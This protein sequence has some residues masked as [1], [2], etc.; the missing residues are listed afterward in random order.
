MQYSPDLSLLLDYLRLLSL[1]LIPVGLLL[2]LYGYKLFKLFIGLIGFLGGSVVGFSLSFVAGDA[3]ITSLLCG[4]IGAFLFYALYRI[5]LF[6]TG[7][8]FGGVISLI[9]VTGISGDV[10]IASFLAGGILGGMLALQLEKLIVIILSSCKGAV[11]VLGGSALL[12]FPEQQ[13]QLIDTVS[14]NPQALIS[15]ILNYFLLLFIVAL[16]GI[17]YQYELIPNRVDGYMPDFLKRS[18]FKNQKSEE[19]ENSEPIQRHLNTNHVYSNTSREIVDDKDWE[20]SIFPKE[21]SV[22]KYP[23]ASSESEELNI[24][25]DTGSTAKSHSSSRKSQTATTK[26]KTTGRE[27]KHIER[28]SLSTNPDM[29]I[30][31]SGILE[32]AV[33]PYVQLYEYLTGLIFQSKRQ[34]TKLYPLV[35]LIQSGPQAGQQFNIYGLFNGKYYSA[36]LGRASNAKLNHVFLKDP[37]AHISRLHAEIAMKGDDMYIRNISDSNPIYLNSTRVENDAFSK[38]TP[39]D[40]V[41]MGDIKVEILSSK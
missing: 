19:R 3:L 16:A 1:I 30:N 38:L 15:L 7:F 24:S 20:S 27:T 10:A 35:G 14:S 4:I 23:F 32:L 36:T 2:L 9:L 12:V 25:W 31:K 26:I 41:H 11:L 21:K 29:E 34:K 5:G 33:R 39:G 18:F 6:L 40:K 17:F 22:A 28:L 37:S 8:A 13:A